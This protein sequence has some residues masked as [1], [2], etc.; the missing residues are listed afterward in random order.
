METRP[1]N[2]TWKPMVVA[3][4]VAVLVH[5]QLVFT[6]ILPA[7]YRLWASL[8]PEEKR[9]ETTEVTMV[10]MPRSRW[11]ANRQIRPPQAETRVEE[12]KPQ[13]AVTPKEQPKEPEKPEDK[14]GGQVVDVAP[15]PDTNPP[16]DTPLQSEHNT[17]VEKQSVSR[18]RSPDYGIAQPRPTMAEFSRRST[19]SQKDDKGEAEIALLTRERGQRKESSGEQGFA[20][21]LPDIQKRESLRLKLD[22]SM[23][24]LPTYEAS[25]ELRGNSDRLRLNLGKK[26]KE[27]VSSAGDAGQD[28][29]SMALLKRPTKEQLAMVTGAPANDHVPEVDEGDETLLNSREFKYATFFNRVKRGVS[30]YWNPGDAYIQHDPYGNV[31]GVK[32]RYTVLNVELDASGA[33]RDISVS[34]SCG[35]G[36]LDDVAA[37][38]FHDASPFPNP[39]QGLLSQDGRIRFQFGFYFEIGDRPALKIYRYGQPPL[40][41]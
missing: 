32:D 34:K 6:D 8:F 25:N 5:L 41:Y 17:Q 29:Q 37:S 9:V 26:D 21:E 12:Q 18:F 4:L 14:L 11:E 30:N 33:V 36:F 13:S 19:E 28:D 10:A 39:P 35:L 7:L 31:Y 1:H 2:T 27:A 22:L 3:I 38:A 23:G 24:T 20:F 40:P 16:K 15:T